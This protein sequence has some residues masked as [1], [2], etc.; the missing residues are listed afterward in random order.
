MAKE[1]ENPKKTVL[2]AKADRWIPFP[3]STNPAPKPR[4]KPGT[5]VTESP[6][7]A[8]NLWEKANNLPKMDI[9]KFF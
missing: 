7:Q 8:S 1:R 6:L 9:S 2:P 3:F 4:F 5:R